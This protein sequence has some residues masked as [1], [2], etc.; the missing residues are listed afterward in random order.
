MPVTKAEISRLRGLRL[1]KNREQSRQFIV[2]G[3]KV[4]GELIAAGHAFET[5]YAT[6]DW[7]TSAVV[8]VETVTE[9][10]MTKISHFP[11]PSSVLAVGRIA[12]ATLADD[13]LDKGFTLA[14]DGVQDPG[15][16]GTMLRIADWFGF[17]RV[18][19]S[20]DCADLFSQKVVNA[21]MGSFAR[22]R[23]VTTDLAAALSD[24][25]VPVLGCD[26]NGDALSTITPPAAA[27]VV[28][29][30]EGRGL[31]AAVASVLTR[32]ITIPRHGHAESL[33]AGVAAGIVC[34]HLRP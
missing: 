21:S 10:E 15:N 20:P 9:I 13:E 6:P 2:E 34:A 7:S 4:V 11:T 29:G 32:R 30:S 12:R 27:V 22:M 31:S 23:V 18:L 24:A 33:N 8:E 19:L 28:I 14:L 1:K 16:V 26:L 3:P 17:A 25:S 5:I